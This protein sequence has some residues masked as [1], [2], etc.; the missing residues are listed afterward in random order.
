MSGETLSLALSL[1]IRRKEKAAALV[2]QSS[3]FFFSAVV[4]HPSN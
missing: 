1:A 3:R 2:D 4:N